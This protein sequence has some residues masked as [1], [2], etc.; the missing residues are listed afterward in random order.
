MAS[1]RFR[2]GR[3]LEI[4]LLYDVPMGRTYEPQDKWSKRAKEENFRA[5]SVYKL[6]ELDKR[7]KLL[8]QGQTVLDIGAAP[9]SWLQ[10]ISRKIGPKGKAVGFD[11][12]EIEAVSANVTTCVCDITD[13]EML[14]RCL[15]QAQVERAD[16]VLSDIAPN[17]SGIKDVDQW[18]SVELSQHVLAISL[19]FLKKG[20]TCVMKVFRGADFDEFLREVKGP[21]KRVKVSMVKASRQSSREVYIVAQN[22]K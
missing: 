14:R 20:G 6:E 22:K 15:E 18:R 13:E 10:Y 4:F 2:G 5:R 12:Q 7:F 11:L 9:G 17:T 19:R 3:S 8:K 16:L 1:I 21:F